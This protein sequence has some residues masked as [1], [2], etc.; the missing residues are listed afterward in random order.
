MKRR[1]FISL[2]GGAAVAWPFAARAQQGERTRRIGGGMRAHLR[3]YELGQDRPANA[4][5]DCCGGTDT[6]IVLKSCHKRPRMY[7]LAVW[8]D[9]D[10]RT[11]S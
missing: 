11:L 2:L 1:Q 7:W 6:S 4:V 8:G 10:D 5:Q 3:T 9:V